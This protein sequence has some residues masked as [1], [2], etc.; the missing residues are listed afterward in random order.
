MST[1]YGFCDL[2]V[3]YVNDKKSLSVLLS[4]LYSSKLNKLKF[5]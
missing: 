4:K 3:N 2:H 5:Q 1:N